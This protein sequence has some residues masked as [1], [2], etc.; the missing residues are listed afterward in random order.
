MKVLHISPDYYARR[1]YHNLYTMLQYQCTDNTVFALR[2]G[3]C[4]DYG[5]VVYKVEEWNKKFHLYDRITFF[6]KQRKILD[7]IHYIYSSCEFNL[8]HAHT[9]F[10]SGY[11]A[12]RINKINGTPYI[13]VIRNT[14]VNVFF[15]YMLHLRSVGNSI[16]QNA[17]VPF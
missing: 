3:K 1:L 9:L 17:Q 15:K 16:M 8:I 4:N 10:S 6:P 12:C 14:D 13:V 2:N 7:R 5:E 11:T